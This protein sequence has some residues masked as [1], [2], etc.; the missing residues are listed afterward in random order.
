M[1]DFWAMHLLG[2]DDVY[3]APSKIEALEIANRINYEFRNSEIKPY[4]V[5]VPWNG[6]GDDYEYGIRVWREEW[7]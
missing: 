3:A 7:A 6:S 2:P 1:T 5:V 4:A